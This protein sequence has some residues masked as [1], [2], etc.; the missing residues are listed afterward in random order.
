[1]CAQTWREWFRDTHRVSVWMIESIYPNYLHSSSLYHLH[2]C[3]ILSCLRPLPGYINTSSTP[4]ACTENEEDV[5]A[6]PHSLSPPKDHEKNRRIA[7]RRWALKGYPSLSCLTIC[8]PLFS[9][10]LFGLTWRWLGR[11]QS[12]Q[13]INCCHHD[14]MTLLGY[15]YGWL[16]TLFNQ[17][18]APSWNWLRRE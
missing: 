7:I 4:P 9:R 12:D 13:S 6:P 11:W 17:V 3:L 16:F 10:C 15:I 14:L 2:R 8:W 5:I 18:S 1:M